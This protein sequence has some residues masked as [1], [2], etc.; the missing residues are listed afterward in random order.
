MEGAVALKQVGTQGKVKGLLSSL[1]HLVGTS[2]EVLREN[3]KQAPIGVNCAKCCF[4]AENSSCS[5]LTVDRRGL[6]CT[7]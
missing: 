6:G 7:G 3:K 1:S 2:R 5:D 4:L